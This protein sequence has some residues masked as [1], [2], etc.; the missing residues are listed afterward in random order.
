M[1]F[2]FALQTF[3]KLHNEI[4]SAMN[5]SAV[6]LNDSISDTLYYRALM[7]V[8]QFSNERTERELEKIKL[9]YAGIISFTD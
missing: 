6:N 7:L 1:N 3:K 5:E 8:R 4:E 9:K 2:L